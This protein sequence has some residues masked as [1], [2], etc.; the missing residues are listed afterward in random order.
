MEEDKVKEIVINVLGASSAEELSDVLDYMCSV[1]FDM[2]LSEGDVYESVVPL[3]ADLESIGGEAKAKEVC[4]TLM[5]K[6][7]TTTSVTSDT[8]TLL[9]AP[10]NIGEQLRGSN[11]VTDWLK[12][13]EQPTYVDK[14]YLETLE[15]K[16]K[17]RLEK[18]ARKEETKKIKRLEKEGVKVTEG[19]F[20]KEISISGGTK[21]LRIEKFGMSY[22][23]D[24]LLVDADL[25]CSFGRRYGLVGRN[26]SGKSTLLR[27]IS[28]KEIPVPSS[29]SILHVEQ[30]VTGD[31]MS[32]LDSVISAD[33]ELIALWD[34]EKKL[35][36]TDPESVR[37]PFVYKRLEA[38]EADSAQARAS[39]ILAGLSFTPD[40]Q[41]RPTKSFSGGWRMRIA[42]A[43]ALF[44]KPDLLLLDEPTN[45][46][47][48]HAVVWLENFLSS[49]EST[50]IIVSH[51]REFLNSVCT[52]I[53]HLTQQKLI[54]YKG[55][56]DAFEKVA[57][58]KLRQ[59]HKAFEAQQQQISHIQRF[60]D[61]FRA[62][63]KR[64]SMAQSRIKKLEKMTTISPIVEEGAV[65][66]PFS[67][68]DPLNPP[69]LQF[70]D[71]TFAYHEGEEPLFK[72]LNLGIDLD[73][74]VALVG[75]N[76]SGKS[77]LLKLFS[78]E[79]KPTSGTVHRHQRLRFAT[80]SQHFVD[81]M[82][83]NVSPL[84]YFLSK[85]P[86]LSSQVIRS[87]LG[88][89]GIV[90]DIALR[91]LKTLS[92]G[93]KSRV[94][95]AWLAWTRPHILLLDEP[96]NHLDIETI[97]GLSQS[98][99]MF[100]GGV[101]IVSHDQRLIQMTCDTIWNLENNEVTIWPGDVSD[102]KNHLI[103]TLS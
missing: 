66:L 6:T 83:L 75:R 69:I 98:L 93:Q 60:I 49:W 76:G 43:R 78:G 102:Y 33:L 27:N 72:N 4:K 96:S 52:D 18:R 42:L 3:I 24:Q 9:N 88:K 73:S 40:M 70:E 23:R 101:F 62:N 19:F 67:D 5:N 16:K 30:E 91:S 35:L 38:I 63:A 53:I 1:L 36:A 65:T 100:S 92:G 47:D 14:D 15:A 29:I 34:E 37:L 54:P 28:S 44:C 45:H 68:P 51:Q 50:L 103:S 56:Y 22:G 41:K 79:L 25:L 84:E 32:A 11:T 64:A 94:V 71:V 57:S 74:R 90:G 20:R 48:F 59:Q 86:S 46:L 31:D 95:F 2:T 81:Q 8:A 26:G 12:S 82:D 89:Y 17:E 10:I 99:T 13:T 85:E 58:E 80:F 7:R 87:H 97:E 61:R 77:T 21:D 39:T 55:N